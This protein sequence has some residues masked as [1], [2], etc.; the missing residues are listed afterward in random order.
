VV[1]VPT[2]HCALATQVF[3]YQ[4]IMNRN[5]S[6]NNISMTYFYFLTTHNASPRLADAFWLVGR[7]SHG[8]EV[9]VPAEEIGL[10]SE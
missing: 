1:G 10:V 6:L 8:D 4:L 7:L 2:E 3:D 5:R 9:V